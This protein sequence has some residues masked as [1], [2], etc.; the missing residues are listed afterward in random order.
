MGAR[1]ILDEDYTVTNGQAA[2]TSLLVGTKGSLVE[3]KEAKKII[4]NTNVG[5][6]ATKGTGIGAASS[7]A[8]NAGIYTSTRDS[9]IG[10]AHV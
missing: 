8:K 3:T 1:A 2:S 5:F 10:R 6:I 9:E 4:T 7:T